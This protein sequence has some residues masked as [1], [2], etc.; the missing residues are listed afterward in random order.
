M[1]Y[2]QP[3]PETFSPPSPAR[4]RPRLID[5][6]RLRSRQTSELWPRRDDPTV[7]EELVRR[8]LPLARRLAYRYRNPNEPVDDLI[9]VASLGLLGA[10]RRFE[11]GYGISF[12]AFAIPTILGELKRHFRDT[13]WAV[14]VPRGAQE[15][16]LRVD[17]AIRELTAESGRPPELRDLARHLHTS[18]EE[19]LIGLEA[20]PAHYSISLD[21]PSSD[22]DAEGPQTI[23]DSIGREDDGLGLVEV[24][25]ALQVAIGQ[26]PFVERQALTLRIEHDLKQSEIAERLGCS[27]MQ[28]SRLL[29]RASVRLR[30]L[31]DPEIPSAAT[32]VAHR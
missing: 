14:H 18:V 1:P 29:R 20:G 24:A 11:P 21:A 26:L 28:I 7:R 10:I 30:D 5:A 31:I 13:G 32:P 16:A 12:R 19:V 4:P 17:R 25:L 9:Q 3:Y 15:T 6:D 22:T 8:F 23:A 2:P 27:Q